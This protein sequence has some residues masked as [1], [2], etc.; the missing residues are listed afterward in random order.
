MPSG[1]RRPPRNEATKY[2]GGTGQEVT[3]TVEI[4][5]RSDG[6]DTRTPLHN[7]ELI[8]EAATRIPVDVRESHPHM[9]WRR[10]V[11]TRNRLAHDYLGVD[12]DVVWDIVQTEVPSLLGGVAGVVSPGRKWQGGNCSF[13]HTRK[14]GLGPISS[15]ASPVPMPV[16]GCLALPCLASQA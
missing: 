2:L 6:Y 16:T 15:W 12:E 1:P 9:P 11:G 4:N 5:A 10:I 14:P 8:G 3:L 7:L 13:G